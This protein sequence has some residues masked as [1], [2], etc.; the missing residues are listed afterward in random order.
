MR[1]IR[2]LLAMTLGWPLLLGAYPSHASQ[3]PP[4]SDPVPLVLTGEP[5]ADG[6]I[7]PTCSKCRRLR[8]ERQTSATGEL[9]GVLALTYFDDVFPVFAGSIELTVV[10]ADDTRYLVRLDD[11]DLSSGEEAEWIIEASSAWRWRDVDMAWMRLVP[12]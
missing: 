1:P 11:V 3:D 6:Y 2:C 9:Q 8:L 7:Q 12:E 4:A 10:L 5:D